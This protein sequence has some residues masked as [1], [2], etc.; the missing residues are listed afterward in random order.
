MTSAVGHCNTLS[1][2]P[3]DSLIQRIL[4][5]L[6]RYIDSHLDAIKLVV[7]KSQ[8]EQVPTTGQGFD[9]EYNSRWE[10]DGEHYVQKFKI[11]VLKRTLKQKY[12]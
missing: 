7:I 9:W 3:A 11:T 6:I 12:F 2:P 10:R 5:A 8:Y 1:T 4:N